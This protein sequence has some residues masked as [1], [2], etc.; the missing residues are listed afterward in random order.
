[1]PA[2]G[3]LGEG[4]DATPAMPLTAALMANRERG[5]GDVMEIAAA[6]SRA[7]DARQARDEAD[8]A[9]DPDEVAANLVARG[10]MPGQI[11]QLSMR[12]GDTLAELEAEQEKLEKATRRAEK[13]R[14]LHERGQIDA[15]GVVM[16]WR[17]TD[18]GDEATVARLERR[19]DSLQ[20]QLR[21]AS[22]AMAPPQERQPSGVEAASRHA[23][24][25]LAQ[26]TRSQPRQQPQAP[27]ERPPFGD[28]VSRGGTEH[29]GPGCRICAE[30][31]KLDAERDMRMAAR[32]YDA[33]AGGTSYPLAY[34]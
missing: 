6:R 34:R 13:T 20:R 33:A 26:V 19:R 29:T 4:P 28:F 25:T 15:A 27:Q 1:M 31:R 14:E 9:R 21:E 22:E 24:R 10:Y 8:G 23:S 32:D 16:R 7:A 17:D 30:G 18:E 2:T 5:P 3:W 12:L 11:T